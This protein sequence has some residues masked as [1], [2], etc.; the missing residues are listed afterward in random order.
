MIRHRINGHYAAW[1]YD[2][3]YRANVDLI[4]PVNGPKVEAFIKER[5]G[6]KYKC[7]KD[8]GAKVVE[9]NHDVRGF[10][11]QVICLRSFTS[12][13]PVDHSFLAHECFH[14]AEH[15]LSKRGIDL[16]SEATTEPYAYLLESLV[17]RCLI[18]LDTR[19]KPS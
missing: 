3:V 13:D 9:M 12:G 2:E 4:W 5:F 15:I 10:N 11:H 19:H 17:R 16:I 7:P 8:F 6:V 18:L 1:F 14:A